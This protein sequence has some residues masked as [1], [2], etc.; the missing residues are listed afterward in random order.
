MKFKILNIVLFLAISLQLVAADQVRFSAS[1]PST[2]ILDRPFQLVYSL[3]ASGK[4]LKI[5]DLQ[6]FEVLAGPFQS[7]SQSTQIINGRTSSSVS[8]SYTYTLLPQKTGT[9]TIPS[10]SINVDGQKY[11]SNGL[12]IKVLPADDN[13]TKSQGN[14]QSNS[15]KSTSVSGDKIF[16]KAQVSKTSVYEQEPVLVTY[17]LYTLLDV[18]GINNVKLPDFNG[19]MK[20]D[21]KQDG[22][23]QLSYENFNGRNYGTI[24]LHQVLLY[25]QHAGEIVIDKAT[26]ETIVRI[27]NQNQP[28]S[29]FDDFFDSYTNVTKNLATQPVKISVKAL[30]ANKPAGYSGVVGRLSMSSNISSSNV[31]ANEAVT[32]KVVISGSGNLKMIKNPEFQFPDGFELY[33]PKVTN[34]FKSTTSG[35]TGNKVIEYM[36]IPR[37]S[38][39]FE[40][41]ATSFSYFDTESKQYK[42]L[43][44]PVFKLNVQKGDGNEST[45]VATGTFVNK[46]D[47][48]QLA[49]DIRYIDTYQITPGQPTEVL[50][51]TWLSWIMYIIPLFAG[52]GA[53]VVLRKRWRETSDIVLMRNK[54]ANRVALKRLKLAKKL[55]DEGKKDLFY[56]EIMKAMWNYLS[57][58]LNIPVANLT[59]EN[60]VEEI[61]KFNVDSTITN[62][63]LSILNTCEFARFAPTGGQQEMGNLFDETLNTITELENS[64]NNRKK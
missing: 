42:V 12:T 55:L 3:N 39:E 22:N 29:I 1:A 15:S 43:Q 61:N 35:M 62:S 50:V 52:L 21:F 4:D 38:G 32:I 49:K 2:V 24:V 51:G 56:E 5:P 8:Y 23:S 41:P 16:V 44:T 26:F 31:K 60:V 36:F 58:K 18:A 25:P 14:S 9:Y 20:Q 17:K 40:I 10:G 48:K 45:T 46:E 47:V 27:Q 63:I 13:S 34:N 28:R 64:I 59:K 37:H 33:D 57:D 6:N 7:Y 53:F 11:T 19:F 54:K 30:P